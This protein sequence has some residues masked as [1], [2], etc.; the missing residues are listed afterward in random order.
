M[1]NSLHNIKEIIRGDFE[2]FSKN[3]VAW[4]IIVGLA[5]IPS[6]YAWFNISASWDPYKNTGN[7]KIAIANDDAGYN[8]ELSPIPLNLGETML[9]KIRD[10]N[11]FNWVVTDSEEAREGVRAG[12]YY[13]SIVIPESFSDDMLSLFSA[14]VEHAKIIYYSNEKENAIA[15]TVTGKGADYVQEKISSIFTEN[16]LE[17]IFNTLHKFSDDEL[18]DQ[19]TLDAVSGIIG[20]LKN[21]KLEVSAMKAAVG[22]M[23]ATSLALI[24]MTGAAAGASTEGFTA[25]MR[26]M[27]DDMV[28][29]GILTPEAVERLE[30]AKG[31]LNDIDASSASMSKAANNTKNN[32]IKLNKSLDGTAASLGRAEQS[33]DKLINKLEAAAASEDIDAIMSILGADAAELSH[34]LAEPVQLKEERVYPVANYGSAMAPFYTSLAIWVGGTLMVS[35]LLVSLSEERRRKLKNFS[36]TQEYVGR[37]VLFL[38][39]GLVQS[40]IICCGNLWYLGIQCEH[41]MLFILAGLV[42]SVVFVNIAYTLTAS[43]GDV[44]K[45]ICVILLV[46]QVAGSGGT[47]PVEMEPGFFR[48]IHSLLPFNYSMGAMREAIAGTYGTMYWRDLG[49]LLI[50]LAIS[51]ILGLVLRRPVIKLNRHLREKLEDTKVM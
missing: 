4:V 24:D 26:A 14:D 8:G 10:N 50:F 13:A 6:L 39:I 43:F 5:V 19:Y 27:I 31:I 45:A 38:I 20:K 30:D 21:L 2:S 34:F 51:L 32:L 1:R 33:L 25:E 46:V 15:S 12:R 3:L 48:A 42:S 37:Y 17:M 44:G 11:N 35:M 49:I 7:I 22:S 23:K 41:P 16:M 40:L 47:F 18:G 9:S 29:T 36:Y 28:K